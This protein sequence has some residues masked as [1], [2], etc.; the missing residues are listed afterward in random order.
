MLMTANAMN[1]Q[2]FTATS[3]VRLTT[4]A[5]AA[6][7]KKAD[8]AKTNPDEG[9]MIPERIRQ[10][11][12]ED[13]LVSGLFSRSA[14]AIGCLGAAWQRP[15]S[16]LVVGHGPPFGNQH[17]GVPLREFEPI[18]NDG[19]FKVDSI[20]HLRVLADQTNRPKLFLLAI[21]S[22]PLGLRR[23]IGA[24]SRLSWVATGHWAANSLKANH[25]P[26]VDGTN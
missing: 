21:G 26:I 13:G 7:V 12:S 9:L 15:D 2:I 16:P 18:A 1:A 20:D 23:A 24:G 8:P 6:A 17:A 22:P 25:M 11:R 14:G 5:E 19:V 3:E 10:V 4:C